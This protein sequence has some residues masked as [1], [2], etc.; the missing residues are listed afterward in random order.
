MS[1]DRGVLYEIMSI[2]PSIGSIWGMLFY[3]IFTYCITFLIVGGCHYW[4]NKNIDIDKIMRER[5]Q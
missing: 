2:M 5:I 1:S 4:V 3:A